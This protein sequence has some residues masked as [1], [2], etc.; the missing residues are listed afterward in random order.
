LQNAIWLLALGLLLSCTQRHPS[1]GRFHTLATSAAGPVSQ[2]VKPFGLLDSTSSDADDM[3]PY[4]ATEPDSFVFSTD[5]EQ[6]HISR[7]GAAVRVAATG[8]STT[9]T[10]PV[11]SGF[12]LELLSVLRYRGD[13]V[14]VAQQSDGDVS[15][16]LVV[17]L[18]SA[19]LQRRWLAHLPGFNV[20]RAL[21]DSSALYVTCIG[22]LGRIDLES[23]TFI[24]TYDNLYNHGA[25]NDFR[26]PRIAGDSVIFD[27]N[28]GHR[29][30]V[31]RRDGRRLTTGVNNLRGDPG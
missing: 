18:D 9:F 22:F 30:V 24:W 14:L 8:G 1:Q 29:I 19:T 27:S 4:D 20:G 3:R 2:F 21:R 26:T 15:G 10:V 25:F 11:D 7:S 31:D 16:G 23:G 17:R 5:A 13:P 6:F 12:R 28:E